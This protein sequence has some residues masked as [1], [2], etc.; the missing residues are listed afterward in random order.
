MLA[1]FRAA[2]GHLGGQQRRVGGDERLD[3][4]AFLLHLHQPRQQ[5][6]GAD[7]GGV[8]EQAVQQL[9]DAQHPFAQLAQAEHQ[10]HRNAVFFQVRVHGGHRLAAGVEPVA[11]A[12][13]GRLD[14]GRVAQGLQ[15]LGAQGFHVVHQC[16]EGA[17]LAGSGAHAQAQLGRVAGGQHLARA[18]GDGVQQDV[19]PRGGQ[20][21]AIGQGRGQVQQPFDPLD[22]LGRQGRQPLRVEGG[23]QGQGEQLGGVQ[24]LGAVG[25]Q[26]VAQALGQLADEGGARREAEVGQQGGGVHRAQQH[27]PPGLQALLHVGAGVD[28]VQQQLHPAHGGFG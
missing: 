12:L 15:H 18:V 3:A 19:L 26:L 9:A 10:A 13:G 25:Q 6:G 11:Q 16:V 7:T 5:P 27:G 23:G 20:R 4:G 2:L 28:G 21:T 14:G 1:R 8:G 17:R 22:L 24:G